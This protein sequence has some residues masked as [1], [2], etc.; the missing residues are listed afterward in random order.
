[1]RDPRLP[2]PYGP[3]GLSGKAAA[4]REVLDAVGLPVDEAAMRRPLIGIISRI[5]D[6]KS[7]D[8]V[9]AVDDAVISLD[10]AWVMLGT[11]RIAVSAC[12]RHRRPASGSGQH[13]DRVRQSLAT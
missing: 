4:K 13:P 11:A 7:F 3:E 5:V 2:V 10:A 1:M 12:G 8:L 9:A 6:Q